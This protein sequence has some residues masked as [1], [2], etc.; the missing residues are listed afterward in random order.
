M[1]QAVSSSRYPHLPVHVQILTAQVVVLEFDIEPLVDTGFDGGL[2]VPR[3]L[4]PATLAPFGHSDWKL[5][6]ET[7]VR[8]PAYV[9]IVTIGSLTPIPTLVLA[10]G[11]DPLLGRRVIDNFK[12][13]FDHGR[14]L[15]AKP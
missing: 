4:I 8:I 3:D 2:A 6:D 12:L 1:I 14:V 15:T 13:V 7:L 5:A 10:L 9:G 11:D